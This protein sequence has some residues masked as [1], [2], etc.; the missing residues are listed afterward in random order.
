MLHFFLFLLFVFLPYINMFK[1]E[2]TE[3]ITINIPV[4]PYIPPPFLTVRLIVDLF[5]LME[6]AKLSCITYSCFTG[7]KV[8][9]YDRTTQSKK[10]R[11]QPRTSRLPRECYLSEKSA[12][13]HS[14]SAVLR[15]EEWRVKQ[16]ASHS[17]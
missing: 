11:Q 12:R 4:L 9:S 16:V 3:E 1:F 14:L 5:W 8:L 17:G 6:L 10:P 13:K 7:S 2:F 15:F